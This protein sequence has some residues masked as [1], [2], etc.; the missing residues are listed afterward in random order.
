M[1]KPFFHQNTTW[2]GI[3]ALVSALGGFMT[4]HLTPIEA[5]QAAVTGLLGLVAKD[6]ET[7]Q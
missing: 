3:T 1:A 5:I 4:G 6:H 2:L 7:G